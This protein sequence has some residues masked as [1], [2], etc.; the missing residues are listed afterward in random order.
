MFYFCRFTK[1]TMHRKIIITGTTCTGKTTL[2]KKMS[3]EFLI[4]QIDLDDLHFLPNWV[5]KENDVFVND[6]NFELDK[7]QE[8]IVTGSYQTLLKDSVWQKATLIVWL[9]YPLHLILRRY[10][11]RT[12]KRV[13]LKEKCCG[14]NYETL[15]RTFSKESLFLWIFKT[16]WHRKRRMH[17]WQTT[18]FAHKKW[19][20]LKSPKEVHQLKNILS[21]K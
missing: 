5:E 20:I 4:P 11:I 14:E 7:H 18:L 13:F 19:L 8:W 21:N 17:Q 6:V 1:P 9:D 16:Y 10:F 15:S 12:Y 2:G 3:K